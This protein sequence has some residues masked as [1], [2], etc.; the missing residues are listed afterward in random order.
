MPLRAVKTINIPDSTGTAFDHGAFDSKTHRV[1]VA[2]T[3]RDRLEVIDHDGEE[4]IGSVS[5]FPGAA[6]VVADQGRVLVTNRGSAE[7]MSLDALSLE[8]L[9]VFETGPRPNGVAIVSHL[10]LGLVACI[11]DDACGPTLHALDLDGLHQWTID[12]PGRPRWCVT[13]AAGNRIFLAIRDPS[14]VVVARL[15]ELD[16]VQHWKLPTLG[17]HGMDIDH[18]ANLLYVACDGGALVELDTITGNVRGGWALPGVPDATFFNPR[19][20]TVHVA[21]GEPGLVQSVD[22]RNGKST[23]FKTAMGAKTTALVPPDNLY[24]FSPVHQGILVL[25]DD[26]NGAGSA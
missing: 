1:F 12:L 7:L 21:I 4:Y 3:A 13:D 20:N 18:R 15:P 23:Q 5:G 9:N 2:H 10:N 11:G 26:W 17:A 25:L 16:E 22:P 6:G 14:M 19:S 24:V 8:T